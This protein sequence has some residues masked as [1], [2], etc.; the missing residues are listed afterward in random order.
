MVIVALNGLLGYFVVNKFIKQMFT[1]VIY[2]IHDFV[3]QKST[4]I[5]NVLSNATTYTIKKIDNILP[6]WSYYYSK[7]RE[8][9]NTNAKF[10][11]EYINIF[12][13]LLKNNEENEGLIIQNIDYLVLHNDWNGVI[14]L[15]E[16]KYSNSE[17]MLKSC[18]KQLYQFSHDA[19]IIIQGNEE[20]HKIFSPQMIEFLASTKGKTVDE[21]AESY[22]ID[23]KNISWSAPDDEL[24]YN[25][26]NEHFLIDYLNTYETKFINKEGF[27]HIYPYIDRKTANEKGIITQEEYLYNTTVDMFKN[28]AEQSENDV[29]DDALSRSNNVINNMKLER[30]YKH[31]DFVLYKYKHPALQNVPKVPDIPDI[32]D[33]PNS[34]SFTPYN[35]ITSKLQI[36][37]PSTFD[38]IGTYMPNVMSFLST[39]FIGSKMFMK[40]RELYR[41]QN[42][43]PKQ[44]E[45][46]EDKDKDNVVIDIPQ[47]E[48]PKQPEQRS[49]VWDYV[50]PYKN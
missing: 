22:N 18:V 43:R 24:Y 48:K 44:H 12:A 35:N 36:G 28:K 49:S 26:M 29:Y 10:A 9:D 11:L 8:Y 16:E 2:G 19:K 23:L 40:F 45:E 25:K 17:K 14:K 21:I 5:K 38:N 6:I 33:I 1:N 27:N 4:E 15:C 34:T 30:D 32:P 13:D 47:P 3:K 41:L 37:N 42:E 31:I 7:Q 46:E 39:L 50:W 20:Y